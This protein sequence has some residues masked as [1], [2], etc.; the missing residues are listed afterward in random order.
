LGELLLELAELGLEGG[1]LQNL[2]FLIGIDDSVGNK[3]V[4]RFSGML[5]EQ[6]IRLGSVGLGG[7][8]L[9]DLCS[10][11]KRNGAKAPTGYVG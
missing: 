8:M 2:G 5:L 11:L 4:K 9:I 10:G 6:G 3:F 7:K 1:L